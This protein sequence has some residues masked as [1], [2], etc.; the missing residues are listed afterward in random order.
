MLTRIQNNRTATRLGGCLMGL[1]FA[2]ALVV[3]DPADGGWFDRKKPEQRT[4]PKVRSDRLPRQSF[5]QGVLA[6]NPLGGWRLD[7]RD[8]H[9]AK[10]CI[11]MDETGRVETLSGG[12]RAIVSGTVI[13]NVILATQVRMLKPDWMGAG[14]GIKEGTRTPSEVDPDVGVLERAPN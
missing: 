6:N 2:A 4:D 12:R 1:L 9:L 7:D 13:G 10:D 11:L 8:V 14:L 3:A 5:T